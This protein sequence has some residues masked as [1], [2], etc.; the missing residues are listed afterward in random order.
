MATILGATPDAAGSADPA[1]YCRG[2]VQR[3]DYES[4]LTAQFYPKE[5]QGGYFALRAF[6]VR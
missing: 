4:F 1:A 3:H 2:L 6:Y 5:V